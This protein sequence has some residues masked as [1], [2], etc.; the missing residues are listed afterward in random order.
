[1]KFPFST[2]VP[3]I[4]A[5]SEHSTALTRNTET[6]LRKKLAK[7]RNPVWSWKQWQ[8][9][10]KGRAL[11]QVV[12]QFTD[13][14]N[15]SC[16]QC[17]MR[18]ENEY[19]RKTLNLIDVKRMLEAMAQQSIQAVSFTGGEPLLYLKQ[20]SECIR[21]A[22]DLGIPYVR[23]GTNGF[24]FRQHHRPDFASKMHT[25]AETLVE[26]GLYTFWISIDSANPTIHERN[27]GLP[28]VMAGIEKALPIFH[29]HGLYPSANLGINR[30]MG[31][32]GTPKFLTENQEDESEF[33]QFCQSSFREFYQHVSNMGF[34]IVNACY[35]M[36]FEQ[37]SHDAVYTATSDGDFI[38][39]NNREKAVLFQALYDTIPEFRSQLRI[40]TPR[41]SLRTLIDYYRGVQNTADY[42]CHGGI[43]FF[44]V[45]SRDMNTYPCGFRGQENLGKF[46]E[47]DLNQLQNRPHC[48]DCDWECFRDPST[49]IGPVLEFLQS[50]SQLTRRWWK[51]RAQAK[52]WFEDMR[53]YQACNFFSGL[54][55]P[56][57]QALAKF[58]KI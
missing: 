21:Y 58:K 31:A 2:P 45:D 11:G 30:Y 3:A 26:S 36:N 13:Q 49:L 52:L 44:F 40:F 17:G 29:K 20:I 39:F 43:D 16:A 34:T 7:P 12:I 42:A 46:W 55:A 22:R 4:D 6:P 19:D 57:Y 10:L 28:D 38:N 37:D 8:R 24:L 14:C 25:L 5:T 54:T 41:S 56:N 15:A 53:Y 27:R 50:P 51:D 35:P 48:K 18:R 32:G 1:M 23:T 33:Y 9:L 47:L